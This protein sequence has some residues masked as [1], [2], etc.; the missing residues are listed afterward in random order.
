MNNVD[1]KKGTAWQC[2]LIFAMKQNREMHSDVK[3]SQYTIQYFVIH[4]WQ[5]KSAIFIHCAHAQ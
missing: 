1:K 2:L 3:I 5:N 4:S